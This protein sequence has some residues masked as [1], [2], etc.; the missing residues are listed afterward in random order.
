MKGE[1]ALPVTSHHVT[2]GE[3]RDGG[4][5]QE[6]HCLV[7]Q[8]Q[9]YKIAATKRF[10]KSLQSFKLDNLVDQLTKYEQ[11][12]RACYHKFL[13]LNGE[14]MVWMMIVDASFLLSYFKF[15]QCKK[16]QQR[17]KFCQACH[18]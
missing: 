17:G 8:G 16:V 15:M 6:C 14:T 9:S 7:P 12:V 3:N 10:L 11:R 4:Q 2:S 5:R 1:G 18:I 13:D